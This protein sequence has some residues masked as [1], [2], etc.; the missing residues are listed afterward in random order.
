MEHVGGTAGTWESTG[1]FKIYNPALRRRER[2][3]LL[4]TYSTSPPEE[5]RRS[6]SYGV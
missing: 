4:T 2:A 3:S 6:S 1:L 5:L